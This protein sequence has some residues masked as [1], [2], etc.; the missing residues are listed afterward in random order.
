M[1]GL[2]ASWVEAGAGALQRTTGEIT[3]GMVAAGAKQVSAVLERDPLLRAVDQAWNAN[4]M[5]EVIPVDW[6]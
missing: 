3:D 6:G 1:L 4:P 2:G 5:R